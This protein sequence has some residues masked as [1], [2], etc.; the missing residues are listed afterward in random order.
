MPEDVNT[1]S[2]TSPEEQQQVVE[3]QPAEETAAADTTQPEQTEQP[4]EETV[5]QPGESKP[6][7]EAVD[8]FGVPY[9]NRA[10]EWQRKTQELTERLPQLIE[11]AVAKG[12]GT[13]QERQYTIAELERFA[14]DHPEQRP[15]V[16]E[17]KAKILQEHVGRITEEKVR[18]AEAKNEARVIKGQA[19][20]YVAQNYPEMFVKDAWGN[21]QFNNQHPLTQQVGIIMQDPRFANAPDGLI[22]AADIAFARYSRMLNANTQKKVKTLNQ[23]LRKVQKQTLVEG[24]GTKAAPPKQSEKQKAL[25]KLSK[26]GSMEDAQLAIGEILKLHRATTE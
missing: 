2:E 18:A 10:M 3:Q 21:M 6:Q 1:S 5:S 22:A 26:T 20:N 12:R 4:S 24:S 9:K 17:E 13:T 7:Y 14:I 25:E 11:E 23:N 15:Y 16:E 19:F 8:E